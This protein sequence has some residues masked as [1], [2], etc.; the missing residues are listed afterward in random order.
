M[1]AAAFIGPGTLTTA[2]AAGASSGLALAWSLLFALIATVALQELAVRSSLVTQQDLAALARQFGGPL[3]GRWLIAPLI[4]LAIGV[5]NAAYQS[6]NLS[7]AAIGLTTFFPDRFSLIVLFLSAIAGALI[8]SNR[9][10][11][12]ERSLV[13]L[14][15]LMALLFI[16]LAV[17]LLPNLLALSTERLAPRFSEDDGLLVLALIGTTIVP[18]NL[19]LHATAAR[20]RWGNMPLKAA[21]REARWETFIAITIGAVITLAIMSV[22]AVLLETPS[23]RSALDALIH[24]VEQRLPGVG[25]ALVA[26]GLFAAGCSSALAAPI[27]AGWAVCGALGLST[28]ETGTAFKSVAL[29]VLAIGAGLALLANRPQALIVTAQAAN[30]MLL[31]IVAIILLLI[32]NSK[33]IPDPWKNSKMINL[34]AAAIIALVIALAAVKLRALLPA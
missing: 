3:W 19:F 13:A 33:L 12:L 21:L 32:A 17:A 8:L 9:Y 14:V 7:G 27:A 11:W 1:V 24:Q 20:R 4:V 23:D 25:A 18:Y 29:V 26:T 22:A 5:G 15:V 28:D 30:A 34:L 2:T 6:G 31:P 10:R 16:G